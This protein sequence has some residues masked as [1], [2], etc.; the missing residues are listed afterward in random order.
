MLD[1]EEY[2]EQEYFFRVLGER[3]PKNVALQDLLGQ[4]RDE[5]LSTTKLPYAIDFLLTELNH[6]GIVS[7]AMARIVHYF[8]P[9]QTYIIQEA[10]SERGRFDIRIAV[11]VLRQE[12][13]YRAGEPSVVGMFL[14]QFETLCRNRLRYD[15]GLQAIA[16]DPAFDP[17]WRDWIME[18]RH[19]IGIVDFADMV[20]VSSEHYIATQR[21]RDPDHVS[22]H[23]VL[24]GEKEGRIALANR[25]KDPLYFF[26]ALQRHLGYPAVPRPKPRQEAADLIP[27]MVLRLERLETRLKLIEEEQR[28]EAIDLT[29]FFGKSAG[30][31]GQRE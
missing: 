20:Y 15:Y 16:Q 1:P 13:R 8:T 7:T 9:F 30:S 12:A 25:N 29:K 21:R 10:E 11:D 31:P 18:V 17:V 4:I 23:P 3:L 27:Q 6:C 22:V 19:K 14:Y 28:H 26:S 5:I 2:I 24:F